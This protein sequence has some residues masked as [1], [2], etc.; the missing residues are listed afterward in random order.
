MNEQGI[1][2]RMAE[3]VPPLLNR[4]ERVLL[5]V[6]D[7]TRTAPMALLVGELL[8]V[9]CR[10]GGTHPDPRGPRNPSPP[11]ARNPSKTP[12]HRSHG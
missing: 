7:T 1:A 12:R 5:I 3:E 8:E 11:L 10:A 4:G 9:L 2:E 6:P